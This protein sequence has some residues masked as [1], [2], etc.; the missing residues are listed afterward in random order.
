MVWLAI[1]ALAIFIGGMSWVAY[2]ATRSDRW[3]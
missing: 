2:D 1:L 3:N